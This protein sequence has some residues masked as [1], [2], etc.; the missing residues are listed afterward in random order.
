M[1]WWGYPYG[2]WPYPDYYTGY[3]AP[4][5]QYIEQ[6]DA[7]DANAWWY[8]YDQPSGYYPYIKNCPGG[9]KPEPAQSSSS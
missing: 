8:R 4:E 7:S 1:G 2:Y 6:G 3:Y 5:A 9:W